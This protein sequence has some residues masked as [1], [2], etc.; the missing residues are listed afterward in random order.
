MKKFLAVL[1]VLM[2]MV[3][4]APALAEIQTLTFNWEQAA[5]NIQSGK[6]GGWYLYGRTSPTA[7]WNKLADIPFVEEKVTYEGDGTIESPDGLETNWEFC[8]TSYYTNGNESNYSDI[9]MYIVDD[10]YPAVPINFTI[11]IE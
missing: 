4:S 11:K 7:E 6:M 10:T 2:M 9:A 1:A 8:I 5:V 3:V